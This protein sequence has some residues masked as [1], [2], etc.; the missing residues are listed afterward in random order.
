ME[1]GRMHREE[2]DELE[3]RSNP[4]YPGPR[5]CAPSA[6]VRPVPRTI[7]SSMVVSTT[8]DSIR[9][10]AHA[11][12]TC[13]NELRVTSPG[14]RETR[15]GHH[16]YGHAPRHGQP[17]YMPLKTA[18]RD[19]SRNKEHV[20][21]ACVVR[22]EER[23]VCSP[24]HPPRLSRSPVSA[25]VLDGMRVR[26]RHP[27]HPRTDPG[28]H[29]VCPCTQISVGVDTIRPGSAGP[30]DAADLATREPRRDEYRGTH[31]EREREGAYLPQV[32]KS[33]WPRERGASCELRGR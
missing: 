16:L 14:A 10:A 6:H 28:L 23:R 1:G 26:T 24:A 20:S 21:Y 18:A 13:R 33:C 25:C 5:S 7:H 22:T 3:R 15:T 29:F 27:T 19:T 32:T 9:P 12:P 17:V 30:Q 2:Q 4:P 11:A 8:H 31:S